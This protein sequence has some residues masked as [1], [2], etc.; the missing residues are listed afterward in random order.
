MPL[1]EAQKRAQKR[2]REKNKE[3]IAAYKSAYW[4]ANKHKWGRVQLNQTAEI[5]PELFQT[6]LDYEV[7]YLSS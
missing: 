6:K 1:S 5:V 3:R 7:S 4:L 2:W